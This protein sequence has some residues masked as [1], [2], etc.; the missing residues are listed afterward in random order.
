MIQCKRVYDPVSADDGYRVLVDRLWPRG[1]KKTDLHY[2]E[3]SKTLAPSTALRKAFHA[4]TLDFTSFSES[5]HQELAAHQ[6]EGRQLAGRGKHGTVTLL[7]AAKDTQHN[8]AEVL[9]Q[10]L[11]SLD[12]SG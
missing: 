12:E 7:Y 5:Y 2:D 10:W 1:I 9:A 4:E 11:R 6:D 3:W 8:H